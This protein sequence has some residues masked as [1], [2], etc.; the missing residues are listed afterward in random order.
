MEERWK[1][2]SNLRAAKGSPQELGGANTP[3]NLLRFSDPTLMDIWVDTAFSSAYKPLSLHLKSVSGDVLE[4]HER[5][6]SV[7]ERIERFNDPKSAGIRDWAKGHLNTTELLSPVPAVLD[8]QYY[9]FIERWRDGSGVYDEDPAERAAATFSMPTYISYT[10]VESWMPT[11]LELGSARII[12]HARSFDFPKTL[13]EIRTLQIAHYKS[14]E[15]LLAKHSL[16]QSRP[17]PD[18]QQT[19]HGMPDDIVRDDG[20]QS[21][22]HANDA[23]SLQDAP[24][25]A[26]WKFELVNDRIYRYKH[27]A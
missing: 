23:H 1:I 2:T 4:H 15:R 13:Q 11:S 18:I 20:E 26:G 12:S 17:S 10:F 24:S 21:L 7:F 16:M 6:R 9:D 19:E 27:F 25:V 8:Q 5:V 3:A 14:T 22:H